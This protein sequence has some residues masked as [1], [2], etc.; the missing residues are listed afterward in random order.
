MRCPRL[1]RAA[2]ATQVGVVGLDGVTDAVCAALAAA[3]A[4]LTQARLPPRWRWRCRVA[5]VAR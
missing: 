4:A 1:R 5:V 3:L 2:A